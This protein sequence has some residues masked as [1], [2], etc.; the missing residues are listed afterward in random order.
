MAAAGCIRC[1]PFVVWCSRR[2]IEI[3]YTHLLY[4]KQEK[5]KDYLYAKKDRK[6]KA[7]KDHIG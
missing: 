1:P 6:R 7:I 5:N 3:I 4:K 2:T